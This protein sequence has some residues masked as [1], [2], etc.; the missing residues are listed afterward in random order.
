MIMANINGYFKLFRD[1]KG[2]SIRIFPPGDGGE[3]VSYDEVMNYLTENKFEN[4]DVASINKAVEGGK[5]AVKEAVITLNPGYPVNERMIIR[6]EEDNM[7]AI[8]RFYPASNDGQDIDKDEILGD[9]AYAGIKYGIKEQ[10]IDS[11]LKDRQYCYDYIIAEGKKIRQGKGASIEYYF[12]TDRSLRPKK[13]EDGSVD[14]HQL[15]NISH[16]KK[17]DILARLTPADKGDPGI[18]VFGAQVSP[19]KVENLVLKFGKNITLSEDKL[20]IT[21]DVDGHAVLEKDKVF[22]SNTYE[23]PADVDN[24]TGDISYDGNVAVRGNVRTNFKIKA[25]GD[26]EVYGT[27]EGATIVSGGQ[28]ILHRGIQGVSKG[29]LVAKGN[30]VAKFIES[31]RVYTDGFIE[32]EAIIQSN[33]AAKGEINVNGVKG[34]IIGGH[35]RSTSLIAAKTIGSNMG[36][37]TT[38]EVGN[39]P[40]VQDK[41][42]KLKDEVTDKN[43]QLRRL[44]QLVEMLEKKLKIGKLEQDKVVVLKKSLE[45]M[46]TLQEEVK[47]AQFEISDLL[48]ELKDNDMAEI[49]I[50]QDIFQGVKIIIGGEI[51]LVN[52]A[53]SRCKFR[54][55]HGE[56]KSMVL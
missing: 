53:L 27:V 25:S 32:T 51:K 9:I 28:I 52:E 37:N 45:D 43:E 14:F 16:I 29:M 23:V 21:S 4:V 35:V 12:N 38:V 46:N 30:I 3:P 47:K 13:N 40:A 7:I 15:D 42:N 48:D 18:T 6:Y 17:G 19:Y 24:S 56:I 20:T 33:V 50:R 39:D 8:A 55:D 2:T 44:T 36:I 54:K 5:T 10:N 49:R 22:V 26:V 1:E 34:N 11:F 41:I 31:A